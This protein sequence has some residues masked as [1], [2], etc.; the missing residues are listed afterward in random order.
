VSRRR[1]HAVRFPASEELPEPPAAVTAIGPIVFSLVFD[2]QQRSIDLSDL[3][4]PR[5][6]RPLARA[7]AGIGGQ[8]AT[9]R[10]W[11]GFARMVKHLR[12]F[13]A[14]AAAAE[15]MLACDLELDDIEPELLE[16]F[17]AKLAAGYD[18]GS[19]EPHVCMRTVVRLLR[20]AGEAAP[21]VLSVNMQARVGFATTTAFQPRPR[22]LDA[23]PLGVFEAIEAAALADIRRIRD[24]IAG[25]ERLAEA[26]ADP[27][28]AGWTRLENVLW[29][30][31]THGP[32]TNEHLGIW[33]VRNT[34]GG[35]RSVNEHLF[36]TVADLVPLV[37]ALIVQTGLEPEC[38]KGLR[39]DCLVN[40]VRGFVSIAYVKKRARNDS[41]KTIRVRDGGALHFPGGLI[42]LAR[43]LTARGREVAGG[44]MLWTDVRCD[45]VHSSFGT[46]GSFDRKVGEWAD[47]HGLGELT[48]RGGASVRLDLRRLRK[49][50]KSRQYLRAAG[51]LDDFTQ[52]HS[53]QV[54]AR[55]YADID[56]HRELH[57]QAIEAGLRQALEVALPPPV[58][59]DEQGKP[60]GDVTAPLTPAQVRAALS[61]QSDVFLASC[62]DFHASP[63]ARTTGSPCPVPIWGCLEC[64]NAV[65]TTRHLPSL[66]AFAGFLHA[67]RDELPQ[68]EW[69]AR[70]GLTFDRITNGVIPKFTAEQI[71]TARLIAEGNDGLLSIPAQ[72]LEHS[73]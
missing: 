18:Q 30:V 17:E 15:P 5:L 35:V 12:A 41:H 22:P 23:Y 62:T 10:A 70:Y 6:V 61:Q 45:G 57:E 64:P 38:V 31:A 29:Y 40:P 54:A 59:A 63:F 47:R 7:L 37:V 43:R 19:S 25:G 51:V 11:A 42:A 73:T 26:G 21:A 72:I 49:T 52:G 68:A 55:H 58:V 44:D 39:S 50:Y 71:T 33:A 69:Q 3:P 2:G 46:G 20:L 28:V 27:R 36:T 8:D 13:V 67:Q 24:R 1:G 66:L 48:D 65:Y 32:L 34:H 9:V 16:A 53:K 14:F 56:A 60:L 4:C